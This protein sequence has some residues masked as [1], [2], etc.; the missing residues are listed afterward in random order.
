[1][2]NTINNV[3]HKHGSFFKVLLSPSLEPNLAKSKGQEQ[4]QMPQHQPQPEGGRKSGASWEVG[5]LGADA[6]EEKAGQAVAVDGRDAGRRNPPDQT[7]PDHI[8]VSSKPISLEACESSSW[9]LC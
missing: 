6:G 4:S 3:S 9:G 1:M 2:L 5:E 8:Q 7:E